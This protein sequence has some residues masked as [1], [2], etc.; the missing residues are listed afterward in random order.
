MFQSLQKLLVTL[1]Y[2]PTLTLCVLLV[3]ACLFFLRWRRSGGVLMTVAVAWSVLWSIPLASDWLRSHLE[4][5]YPVLDEA[6]LPQADAI[7]VLGGGNWYAW[8]R[9]THVRAEDLKSSRLAAG[10]RA[11]L[12]DRAPVVVLSGGGRNGDSEAR[13]MASAIARLGVP[14]SSV[15]LEE[16]SQS[17]QDNARFTATLLEHHGMD[18]VLLVT[19]SVHMPRAMLQFQR[20]GVDAVAVPVPEHARRTSWA[21]RWLPSRSALWRSGRAI[22]EYGGLMLLYL[23]N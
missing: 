13:M 19:S 7:V 22:K 18:R 12:A 11:W 4:Q 1:T 20:E 8:M 16:R 14:A 21:D 17:T 10:A 15:M 9:R 6:R 23:R 5:Q 2:P 3:A